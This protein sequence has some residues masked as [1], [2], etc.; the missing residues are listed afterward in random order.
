MAASLFAVRPIEVAAIGL[1]AKT[2]TQKITDII[3]A[4]RAHGLIGPNA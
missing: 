4:L 1:D 3:A 2:D